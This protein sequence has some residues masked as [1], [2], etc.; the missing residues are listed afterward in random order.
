MTRFPSEIPENARKGRRVVSDGRLRS[1]AG[2]GAR[3]LGISG[4]GG[5]HPR[6]VPTW[7]IVR[8]R[9]ARSVATRR[10]AARDVDR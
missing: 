10:R 8:N 1:T 5:T 2:E 7:D 3:N 6:R 9:G 4:R